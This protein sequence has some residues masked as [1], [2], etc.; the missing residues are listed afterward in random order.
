MSVCVCWCVG[1]GGCECEGVCVCE[2]VLVCEKLRRRRKRERERERGC[3]GELERLDV[4]ERY[5]SVSCYP[6]VPDIFLLS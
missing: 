4:T 2:D 1:L 6:Q 5:A 3:E